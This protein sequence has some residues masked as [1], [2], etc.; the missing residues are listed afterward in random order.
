MHDATMEHPFMKTI[1][2]NDRNQ[3]S[4]RPSRRVA[5]GVWRLACGVWRVNRD[6]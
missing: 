4:S 2:G 1:Y 3:L 5:C 6:P